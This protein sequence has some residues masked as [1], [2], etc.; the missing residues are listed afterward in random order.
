MANYQ[1]SRSPA[2]LTHTITDG[3]R[4]RLRLIA[5]TLLAFVV[6]GDALSAQEAQPR[7]ERHPVGRRVAPLARYAPASSKLFISVRRLDELDAAM[8]RAHAWRLLPL[9]TG[10]PGTT[11]TSFSLRGA[12]GDFIGPTDSIRVD[13]LMEAESAI[14]APSWLELNRSVWLV[15]PGNQEVLD[16]WAK[17]GPRPRGASSSAN[18]F[19]TDT[20]LMVCVKGDVAAVARAGGKDGTDR[21]HDAHGGPPRSAAGA[22]YRLPRIAFPTCRPDRSPWPIHDKVNPE[23]PQE[24]VLP[25]QSARTSTE[26]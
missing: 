2:N 25:G 7:P 18:F 4:P 13:D 12:L 24:K 6:T 3:P 22:R 20:G 11:D 8:Q 1:R 16:R 5:L 21:Y 9:L 10:N 19:A 14:V 15:R 17:G 26:R 23:A